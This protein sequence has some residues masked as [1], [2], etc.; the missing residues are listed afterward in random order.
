[1]DDEYAGA[2]D[3]LLAVID[4]EIR[5][6]G[7]W[8]GV[9]VLDPA[10]RNALARVPR[11]Q[12]VSRLERGLAYA[13]QPLSIGHGQTISQPYI[14]AIMTQLLDPGP[15]SRVLEI[16]TGCGYQAAVLAEI[17]AG[18]WTI[19]R[20]PALAEAAAQRLAR[21]G[22][23]N[24]HVRAGDGSLGWPEEAPFDAIIVTAAAGAIPPTL[25]DQL[26]PGGRVVIPVGIPGREQMLTVVEKA[27]D[28][29]VAERPCLPVA[30]VPL[31]AE[32]SDK[33][34]GRAPPS[35]R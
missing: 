29:S 28:G 7:K 22:Y 17:A 32:A 35:P 25:V 26:A 21:L 31:V 4:A 18:V 10:V 34:A 24:V 19:E 3:R 14:V 33:K 8:T 1:M 27:G 6:T 23:A 5:A 12:F 11:H 9:A 20:I 13:N 15:K 16:G 2:R 30:F